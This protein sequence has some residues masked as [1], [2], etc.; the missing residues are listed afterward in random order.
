[1]RRFLI[2][3]AVMVLF[4]G[5]SESGGFSTSSTDVFSKDK[6]EGISTNTPDV[7]KE[8]V[9]L[10]F[11]V[12]QKATNWYV[13]LVAEAPERG[14]ITYSAQLGIVDEQD[15]SEKYN[16]S[17]FQP[18][19]PYI[20]I[21]F[22]DPVEADSGDYKASFKPYVEENSERWYFTVK[23]DD[24]E[25]NVVLTWRGLYILTPYLN[26][27]GQIRYKE[28]L[29]RS[30]PILSQMRIVDVLTGD[31]VAII[32]DRNIQSMS[33]NMG[34][35]NTR[36][37]RWELLTDIIEPLQTAPSRSSSFKASAQGST[38]QNKRAEFDM[39]SPPVLTTKTP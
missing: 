39:F 28:H 34:G 18:M 33:F 38:V 24:N 20:D 14:L 19:E 8:K 22:E 9:I 21:V 3:L 7:V 26:S 1:M 16:L 11:P 29:S 37:F 10:S 5:C 35:S 12:E 2:A 6:I 32:Q 15:A 4:V 13:R 30:N 25:S 27:D 17:H 36:T 31:E 23:S